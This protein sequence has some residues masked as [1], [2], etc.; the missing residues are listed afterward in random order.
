[1]SAFEPV[2]FAALT[3]VGVKRSHNQDACAAQPALDAAGF[4]AQGH[5]FVVADGMGGHAVGEKA[6]AKAAR[7][8]PFLYSKHA[9][10]GVI[11]ALRRA[12]QEANAGIYAIGQQNPEFRGLG[13]TSTALIIRPEGAW[14]GHVGDSR[15]YRVRNGV[16][17][18]L[19]FDHS[20]V[21]E[22]ARRQGVDPDEL[23][24]FKKNVIIRS[25]G[26]DPEVEV[27]IEGPHP[28]APGDI[29]LLCSDGLTNVVTPQEA[30]AV[31]TS[32]PPDEAARFL[33]QLANLRGGPDNITVL[34]VE[35]PDGHESAAGA[36]PRPSIPARLLAAWNRRV[37]WPFTVLG[38]GAALALLS[39]GMQIQEVP[40]A[41]ILF[42]VA[43]LF[44][45][46]GLVGLFLDP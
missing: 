9:K 5:V 36:R 33:V 19:T 3:D 30:G 2:R 32:M 41:P 45:V 34:I 38:F 23:G 4:A 35:V 46:G 40:G 24:D 25:L 28:V 29:F 11:P 14:V 42:G 10:D 7:D 1:M 31:V 17:D 6:S 16:A 21:W 43:A 12:F 44:I 37:P 26:P 13:T 22:I 20:W 27:D 8:I 15:A 39:L 18:Q